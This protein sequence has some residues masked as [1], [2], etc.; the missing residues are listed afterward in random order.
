MGNSEFH[1]SPLA[2]IVSRL[3]FPHSPLRYQRPLPRAVLL[4]KLFDL[5]V[6]RFAY[7]SNR[8]AKHVLDQSKMG[9]E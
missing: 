3:L 2:F 6:Q 8:E 7:G 5:L 1:L 4:Q 9:K